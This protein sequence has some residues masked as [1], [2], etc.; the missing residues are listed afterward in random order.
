MSGLTPSASYYLSA[1]ASPTSPSGTADGSGNLTLTITDIS[2]PGGSGADAHMFGAYVTDGFFVEGIGN[3][4][5]TYGASSSTGDGIGADWTYNGSAVSVTFPTVSGKTYRAFIWNGTSGSGTVAGDGT[6]KT[7]TVS[8]TGEAATELL[9]VVT[10]GTG[11]LYGIA[12]RM[13]VKGTPSTGTQGNPAPYIPTVVG[14]DTDGR[15]LVA[16]D[17]APLEPSP[18]WTRI[19]TTDNLVAAADWHRGRQTLRDT[20]DTGTAT[21]YINDTDGVFDPDNVSSPY[22]GKLDGR[23]I[24]IQ[25]WNPV[26]STWVPQFRGFIDNYGYV[27]NP[28]TNP[29]GS[30]VVANV[31]IDCVDVFDYLAGY[32]V[33]PGVDGDTPPKGSEAVVFYEDTAGTVDTRIVQ[34]LTDAGIDSSM[35]VV[36]TGNVSVQETRYDPGDRILNVLRDGADAELP[37]IA[38]LYVDKLGRVVFHGRYSRFDPDTVAADATPGAWNF[39]RWKVGDGVA[40]QA[41]PDTAQIR[42]LEYARARHEIINSM[43]CYPRGIEDED[44]A[45]QVYEDATSIGAFG[46]YSRDATD[47]I[48]K[49]GTTTGNSR[50]VETKKYA[51]LIVKNQKD[52]TSTISALMLKAL[53]PTDPRA[54]ATWA[55]LVGTDVSDIV[56]VTVGYPGGTGIQNTN[57]FIEGLS[58]RMRPLNPSY[59]YVE[60]ELDVSPAVWSMDTHGVFA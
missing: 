13:F 31:Q 48:I 25:C 15:V 12:T 23:Q 21:V 33:Q 57:F 41:D 58:G 45:G 18:V 26:T 24:K 43:V 37:M 51:E 6:D 19:D 35:T 40:I 20:T 3:N 30:L 17:D 50:N 9:L 32:Q 16:F 39:T 11:T 2:D 5:F 54:T 22:F 60:V 55:A 10:L 7:L 52:P 14:G 8:T 34:G 56:N 36:F 4:N 46:K 59:D 47:L 1:D 44:V 29:D 27:I 42:V 28:A 49:A 53:A 38:N